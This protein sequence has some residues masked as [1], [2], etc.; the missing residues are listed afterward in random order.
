MS[1]KEKEQEIAKTISK[2]YYDPLTGFQNLARTL[3]AAQKIDKSIERED[4]KQF[5][6][7]Q[8]ETQF[9]PQT[10]QNSFIPQQAGH[11]MQ[12]DL[13]FA[14]RFP[15]K[16]PYKYALIA[17]DSFS[18]RL[19]VIPQKTKTAA[20]TADALD[21]AVEK[22]GIPATAMMDDGSEFKD[23][24]KR[25]LLYYK[26][27]PLTTRRHA[28]FAERAIRTL[29]EKITKR[30]E[31]LKLSRWEQLVDAVTNQYNSEVHNAT[32]M[33]PLEADKVENHDEAYESM[34]RRGKTN[35]KYEPISVGDDVR[36]LKKP[37]GNRAHFRVG[38]DAWTRLSFKVLKIEPTENGTAYTLEHQP[39]KY[40]RHEVKL[41]KGS[42]EPSEEL[43]EEMLKRVMG[44][45]VSV[46]APPREF[47]RLRRIGG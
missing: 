25:R 7:R 17:I 22:L 43:R 23:A 20:E 41:V 34:K 27:E 45:D 36:L 14:S 11:Q 32:G 38:E 3:V 8:K 33:T 29:K 2:V 16:S 21:K 10:K 47:K 4:V 1:S 30:M 28:I 31:A 37:E 18:K 24:F 46:E 9:R 40:L 15:G 6:E 26:I 5:L 13:A 12:F 35:R 19:A 44:E 39:R 42:E